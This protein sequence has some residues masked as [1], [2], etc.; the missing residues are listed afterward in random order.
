M[1]I[2]CLGLTPL[3]FPEDGDAVTAT[4][5]KKVCRTCPA[6][7]ACLDVAMSDLHLVGIWAATTG[8]ERER[9]RAQWNRRYTTVM[10]DR[11]QAAI[12]ES[13]SLRELAVAA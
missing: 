2:A 13:R 6:Y 8:T 4:E 12:A 3:F 9:L 1:N 10:R 7:F 11:R 5:A